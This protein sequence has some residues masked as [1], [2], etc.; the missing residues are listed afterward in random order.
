MSIPE[1]SAK[2][3]TVLSQ[4]GSF[5]QMFRQQYPFVCN[6]VFRY[7]SDKSK[8]EDIAQEIFAELWM[9]KDT[10][11]IHTSLGAY[12]RRMAVSRALNYIRDTKK[13]N[14]DELDLASETTHDSVYQEATVIQNLEEAELQQKLD[15]AIGKLPEKCRVVF[16]LSR[17]EELSYA[18]IG[19]QL[20]ISIKTVE[21][22]I[23]KAL[24]LLRLALADSRG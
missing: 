1:H 24:K 10:I 8:V 3:A 11:L 21:N 7:V 14:W 16:M 19:R 23:G 2:T 15:V 4:M 12:L 6:V 5:E 13:Y 22:Q 9:K 18:E 20:N 17:Q